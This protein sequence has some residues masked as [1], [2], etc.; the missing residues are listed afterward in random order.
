M[1]KTFVI[2]L[3]AM[4]ISYGQLGV[5]DVVPNTSDPICD[6]SE[7]YIIPGA[8]TLN[9]YDYFGEENGG[10]NYVIWINLFTSW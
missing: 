4:G 10:D 6:N 1:K 3:A 5:G 8:S 2:L 9:L 7:N